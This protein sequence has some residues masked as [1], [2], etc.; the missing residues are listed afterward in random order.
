MPTLDSTNVFNDTSSDKLTGGM[1]N[2]GD[3]DWYFADLAGSN[4]DTITD[5]AGGD[6]LN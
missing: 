2:A 1:N 3:F 4:K 6:A 5:L